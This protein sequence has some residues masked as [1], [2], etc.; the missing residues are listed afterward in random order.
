[1]PATAF[2]LRHQHRPDDWRSERNDHFYCRNNTYNGATTVT[3]AGGTGGFGMFQIAN[4]HAI[5]ATSALIIGSGSSA[6]GPTDLGGHN[7]TIAS[8]STG[9]S[10]R[11]VTAV[12][13]IYNLSVNNGGKSFFQN[14]AQNAASITITPATATST[15]FFGDIGYTDITANSGVFTKVP[16]IGST[17]ALTNISLNLNGATNGGINTLTLA[18]VNATQG[19]GGNEYTGNTTIGSNAV[20]V[21]GRTTAVQGTPGDSYTIGGGGNINVMSGGTLASTSSTSATT[22]RHGGAAGTIILN[23]GSTFNPRRTRRRP[24]FSLS[25]D[26]TAS[27]SRNDELR[28]PAPR[29]PCSDSVLPRRQSNI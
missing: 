28:I 7:I 12:G 25:G 16:Y 22:I 20:L 27:S 21:F 29:R 5:P 17:T 8:L 14:T 11:S 18:P 23:S 4:D 9:T 15:T 3:V 6:I 24:A 13:N 26:L 1:M 10:N 2:Q 19:T